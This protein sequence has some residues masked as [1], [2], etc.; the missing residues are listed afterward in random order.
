MSS[1]IDAQ[2]CSEQLYKCKNGPCWSWYVIIF[3]K[4]KHLFTD[5]KKATN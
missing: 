4:E 2:L 1:Y 5:P 3:F